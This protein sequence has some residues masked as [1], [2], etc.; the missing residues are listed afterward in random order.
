MANVK[1]RNPAFSNTDQVDRETGANIMGNVPSK[2]KRAA[3]LNA[4]AASVKVEPNSTSV[5]ASAALAGVPVYVLARGAPRFEHH[6]DTAEWFP[7]LRCDEAVDE[8]GALASGMKRDGQIEPITIYA[9][10][11]IDGRAREGIATKNGLDLKFRHLEDIQRGGYAGNHFDF[12]CAQNSQRR[13]MMTLGQR[14]C[15]AEKEVKRPSMPA[16]VERCPDP[17]PQ[18]HQ[19]KPRLQPR[20]EVGE[21]G[22]FR[23]AYLLRSRR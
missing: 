1:V 8:Y 22:W 11:I 16:S 9:G 2:E 3:A 21:G 23:V 13:S 15:V 19:C 12:A 7:P 18:L 20:A 5:P 6:P 17:E 4:S 10:K 14:D